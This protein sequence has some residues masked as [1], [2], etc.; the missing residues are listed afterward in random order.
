MLNRSPLLMCLSLLSAA[1]GQNPKGVGYAIQFTSSA[2]G[3][4]Q[5]FP[6]NSAAF[7]TFTAGNTGPTA[8]IKILATP[9]GSQFYIVG[10]RAVDSFDPAF[11]A[12]SP[13]NGLAGTFSGAVTSPDGRFLLVEASQGHNSG[14]VYVLNTRA[15]V[16]ALT[17]PVGGTVIGVAV[18]EDSSTA[19]ILGESTGTFITTVS[20]T[21]L[22]QVGTPIFLRDPASE[23]GL[24][25]GATSISLSPMNLLYVT[26]V[27]Q[28]LQIDPSILAT[29]QASALTCAPATVISV[30]A[31]K[32]GPLQYTVAPSTRGPLYAYFVNGAPNIGGQSLLRIQV[33]W[34]SGDGYVSYATSEVFDSIMVAAPERIFAHS[35]AD[36]TLWD[37]AYDLSSVAVSSLQNVL[38]ATT[39]YS[40][41]VTDELPSA[42]YLFAVSGS[43]PLSTVYLVN[44]TSNSLSG[45]AASSAGPGPMQF[46]YVPSGSPAGFSSSPI[47]Y[48][49]SQTNLTA[50]ATAAPLI[51]RNL[52]QNGNPVFG[53]PVTFRDPSGALTI[54]PTTATTNANG[55]AEAIITMGS[56]TGTYPVTMTA[57]NGAN[58][59][60]A[61]FTLMVPGPGSL[62]TFA[63]PGTL[64]GPNLLSIVTGNGQLYQGNVMRTGDPA[65]AL[66]VQVVDTNGNPLANQAVTFAVT[67]PLIGTIDNPNATTDA[68][69]LTSTDF[70]PHLPA[71]NT[72]FEATTVTASATNSSGTPIGS[73]VFTETVYQ[74]NPD[75]TGAPTVQIQLPTNPMIQGGEGDTLPDAVQAVVTS[76]SFGSAQPIPNIALWITD[77]STMFLNGPGTCQGNPVS[78]QTGTIKCNLI[79]VCATALT[80]SGT[81]YGLGLHGFSIDVGEY[82]T[83][84]NYDVII[85]AGTTQNLHLTAGN[86]QS[87]NAG[88]TLSVPLSAAV[89]DNCGTGIPGITVTWTV[90]QGSAT[91]STVSSLTVAGG[92]TS[93]TVTLGNT[94][95]IVSITA[96][97][98]STTAV[99]F[100]ETA[101]ATV[102]GLTLLSGSGQTALEGDAFS[103]P[104]VFALKDTK[105]NP[106][107]GF[108]VKF[109]VAGGIASLSAT[110]ELTNSQGLAS[111][112]VTAG[113]APGAVTIN[114]NFSAFTATATLTVNASGAQSITFGALSNLVLG[115]SPFALSATTS[116]GLS[117]IYVSTTPSVCTVSGVVLTLV[118]AGTCSITASQPGNS[119]YAAAAPVTQTFTITA[120]AAVSITPLALSFQAEEGALAQSGG[121]LIASNGTITWQSSA[122]T[123]SGGAW[124]STSGSGTVVAFLSASLTVS[125]NPVSLT[126]GTYQGS[127]TI[128]T[129]GA[130]PSFTTVAVTLT[131]SAPS[132]QS[133]ILTTLH[134]FGGVDGSGSG[135][136][137]MQAA[138]GDFYG[139]TPGGGASSACTQGCGTIFRT[140]PSGT[141]TMLYSFCSQ[142]NC[143]DGSGP[144]AALVQGTDGNFYGTTGSG[145]AGKGGTVFR[146]TPSGT[147]ATLYSFCSQANCADG[148]GPLGLV[149]GADGNLY[150]T[151]ESGG[152]NKGGTVFKITPGGALATLYNFCSQAN[153]TDGETPSAALIQGADGNFYGTTYTGGVVLCGGGCGTVFRIAPSGT[154][155]TLYSFPNAEDGNPLGGLI[156]GSDGNFY[157]TAGGDSAQGATIFGI[158]SGGTLLS[159]YIFGDLAPAGLVQGTD[160]NIYGVIS[161]DETIFRF[162]PSTPSLGG[163]VTFLYTFCSQSNCPDGG[164]PSGLVQDANGNLYGTAGFGGGNNPFGTVFSL[165]GPPALPNINQS[166]DL[167]TTQTG[168]FNGASFQVVVAPNA[169]ITIK[170]TGLSSETDT[171][172]NSIMNGNLPTS[173]DGVKVTVNGAPAY[174]AY[175]SPTQI[176]ALAPNVGAAGSEVGPVAFV[177][178]TNPAGTSPAANALYWPIAP[179]FFQ[180]GNYAVAT[181]QDYS[182]AVKNGTFPG[183]TT[184]PAK[185][186]DVIILWGTGFGPTSPAAPAGVETPATTTYNAANPVTVTVGGL[187]ATV[188]GAALAPGFAGLYQVAIQIPTSLVNGDYSVV[189][190]LPTEFGPSPST[191]LIT[192]QN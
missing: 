133:E 129:P 49:F 56:N 36:T 101:N 37:V 104:L 103:Q 185:P 8:P 147:L 41:V 167:G 184:S 77:P 2:S 85:A 192:V 123:S 52:D 88:A 92:I 74:N 178:V 132:K 108:T 13:I 79:P 160:G 90:T 72:P 127:V 165:S 67:G 180:W 95:G 131:V 145:G 115:A 164:S 87:G 119:T 47:T 135:A 14:A 93:T 150:G 63:S 4:F 82:E 169:W 21:N 186:G 174:V 46:V 34:S 171:W 11:K 154:L 140:T 176:N 16:V 142:A 148:S 64:A 106:V 39:V 31:Q 3:Q 76:N 122:T 7:T 60:S 57:T 91:L 105:G 9:D 111:V 134:S 96:S 62:G 139:T 33:P 38:P 73:V 166:G 54:T 65:S 107:A 40:A 70:L 32:P 18:S 172:A 69:G 53:V 102:G 42:H 78:D 125:I 50:D 17:V 136:A 183:V 45:H 19:W 152:A 130:T 81:P 116:S 71:P 24:G 110:S 156:E 118:A 35:P 159:R 25:G 112:N 163:T 170:G 10:S 84:S 153:C 48:N 182:L 173:L 68:T 189:A 55:Y 138:N 66:T 94:P 137:L 30:P 168:L 5:V 109:S 80:P 28:I 51:V 89:A 155:T 86:N 126:A 141:F 44:L 100:T 144:D 162:T 98:D 15:N 128:Q 191:T 146:I 151:T 149:E 188:Y 181:R 43:A 27:N 29:C 22:A 1:F 75:G 114:A 143:T 187:A 6:E 97:I 23:E 121:V 61:T 161:G 177:T 158:S 117:V 58:S 124:L 59:V 20:L 12:A 83:F 157:G 175:I 99:T 190:T 113:N 26:A 120:A 179:A